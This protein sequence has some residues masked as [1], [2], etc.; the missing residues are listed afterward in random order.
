MNSQ[1]NRKFLSFVESSQVPLSSTPS[2]QHTIST[3]T[4][5]SVPKSDSG[6]AGL[7]Q[8][9]F[10][11]VT[12]VTSTYFSIPATTETQNSSQSTPETINKTT[13]I[14]GGVVLTALTVVGVILFICCKYCIKNKPRFIWNTGR[15]K[16]P[17]GNKPLIDR[18]IAG[19]GGD[20]KEKGG[21][22]SNGQGMSPRPSIQL[23]TVS[24]SI[25]H[26]MELD[27]I[28]SIDSQYPR[29]VR[30]N[31]TNSSGLQQNPRSA[32]IWAV[33]ESSNLPLQTG[34]PVYN[35]TLEGNTGIERS[36]A[37]I[38]VN[39]SSSQVGRIRLTTEG[40]PP[41][42]VGTPQPSITGGRVSV[43]PSGALW[44][45]ISSP[46]KTGTTTTS[47]S[48]LGCTFLDTTKGE[49]D[50]TALC[51]RRTGFEEGSVITGLGCD[52]HL[53]QSL[54]QRACLT[55]GQEEDASGP[56]EKEFTSELTRN[57][58][59]SNSAITVLRGTDGA[60]QNFC[61][62]QFE[63]DVLR[64]TSQATPRLA[65]AV[66]HTQVY[67]YQSTNRGCNDI[68]THPFPCPPDTI[69]R[70]VRVHR[71]ISP[72]PSILPG[73][74]RR[75]SSVMLTLVP[76]RS[77][78]ATV[79]IILDGTG[80]SG[81]S[82]GGRSSWTINPPQTQSSGSGSSPLTPRQSEVRA[83]TGAQINAVQRSSPLESL[84]RTHSPYP[85][86]SHVKEEHCGDERMEWDENNRVQAVSAWIQAAPSVWDDPD[87]VSVE[88]GKTEFAGEDGENIAEGFEEEMEIG[89][90][91]LTAAVVKD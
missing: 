65:S 26:Q 18:G 39:Q 23:V 86:H 70:A 29:V 20:D 13:A 71:S 36:S 22:D 81:L 30:P 27:R 49:F 7:S 21:L 66:S 8:T 85:E 59:E 57:Y 9:T 24:P 50:G 75:P 25:H 60:Y 74:E 11:T 68:N 4:V 84:I 56:L 76:G 77:T 10:V 90:A 37:L 6:S 63:G 54:E 17:G 61:D 52:S 38:L 64:W 89:A 69:P 15:K 55:V 78:P 34:S 33:G 45:T 46:R 5:S 51:Q 53:P 1:A 72:P 47:R 3:L 44:R 73:P 2:P 14:I 32:A 42:P 43:D 28:R 80:D 40:A 12:V 88:D 67:S 83:N 79:N 16:K 82:I 91:Q 48:Q 62:H 19:E 35:D 41:H 87:L 31:P 58:N